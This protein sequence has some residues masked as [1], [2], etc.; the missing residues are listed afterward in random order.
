VRRREFIAV[1]G[2][3]AVLLPF[4]SRAE[5][6]SPTI[7]FLNPRSPDKPAS[8]AV[9]AAFRQ[10]I[11]ETG[12]IEGQNVA[13]EYRW[14]G[15]QLDELPKLASDLV[16][17]D[18]T[19]IVAGATDS[20][21]AAM[22]ATQTIPI[23]F[24]TANDPV[25]VGFVS[26]LSRPTG[27]VTGVSFYSS[28]LAAKRFELLNEVLPNATVGLLVNPGQVGA[29]VQVKD[30]EATA[31]KIGKVARIVPTGSPED[32]EAA[33]A[34][35]TKLQ[36]GALLVAVDGRPERVAALAARYRVPAIFYTREFVQAGGLMSYGAELT[37]AYRQ[38]GVYAG[39]ILK[40]A[41]P[42]ELPVV[43]P[44]RFQL[45]INRRTAA[46]LGLALPESLLARADEV[47]E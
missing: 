43:Q 34:S 37:D 15:D 9:V 11:G 16:R 20:V 22:A 38:A 25:Q 31:Q 18:V 41:K 2:R 24:T 12:F 40:G 45:V 4:P 10:G 47:I 26:S 36:I 21:R 42:A 13:I 33:F 28:V 32:L 17:R 7:G 23:V 14:A 1:L 30:V 44:T 29:E 3:A 6:A 27:N 8:K 39:Q 5:A 35:L 46:D 19:V